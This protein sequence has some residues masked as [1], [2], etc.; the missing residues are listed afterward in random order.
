LVRTAARFDSA[1]FRK[2]Y[3]NA[4]TRV[5]TAAEMRGRAELIAA[6]LRHVGIP[7]RT[8]LDAGCGIGLM[9]KQFAGILPRAR[10]VGLEASD[11]LC[12]RYG[13]ILGSVTDFAPRSPYDLCV[14]YDVLQYLDDRS[15]ARAIANLANLTRGA[16]Y[17][18]A[19]T[20]EDWR[21]NCDRSRTDRSVYLRSGEWYRRRLKRRFN[22]LGFGVWLRR[23]ATAIL[24]DLERPS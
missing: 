19:L 3:F 7:V 22:Y 5:T 15:A 24:W 2:Y 8:I 10:Y 4:T 17:L 9:R 20:E 11:Y 21:D 12:A 18:S 14:C 6:V 23:D 13:W 16:L 1:Y